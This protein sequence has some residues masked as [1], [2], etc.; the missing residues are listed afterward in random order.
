MDINKSN[1]INRYEELA[2]LLM[3]PGIF[4][5]QDKYRQ[6]VKEHADLEP[7]VQALH[8]GESLRK[9]LAE[10]QQLFYDEEDAEMREM[11]REE[12]KRVS[13]ELEQNE[14]ELQ[15]LMAPKDPRDSKS[16]VIE[17]RGGAGGEEAALFAAVLYKM[18]VAFAERHQL[19]SELVEL[20]E[21]ELGGIK[22]VVFELNGDGA[23]SLFK[24]ESGVHRVQRVPVTES[25]GRIHTSTC[26]VAVMPEADEMEF[27]INPAD[28]QID[29]Y[30]ASGAGGQHV[31]KTS[32]AI[33]ITHLPSGVVVTCQDERSQHKNKEK[34][35]RVL[36]TRLMDMA[37]VEAKSAEDSLRK[38]QVGSGDRSERIRTY[39]YHQGRVSDHRIGL[40]LYKIDEI[41][42]GD[43]DELVGKLADAERSEQLGQGEK[44]LA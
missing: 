4:A 25:G 8:E 41:L 37:L 20:N 42:A 17:I 36:R 35:L 28:L 12:I 16:V 27:E 7:I 24:Y 9:E 2:Q 26:T 5:D 43:M 14:A 1:I 29:T 39:N 11:A 3:D 40:T 32:S 22:E 30:R 18:Y 10:A 34:A 23:Y 6:T 44:E 33:R 13:N 15:R 21:T 31:N 19:T 38:N